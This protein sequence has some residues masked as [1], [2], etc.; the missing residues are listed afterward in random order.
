M[1]D[2]RNLI[3]KI[4]SVFISG[5]LFS[6]LV[7][8]GDS[9]KAQQLQHLDKVCKSDMKKQS[10]QEQATKVC[11]CLADKLKALS[12][13]QIAHL[14]WVSKGKRDKSP[15]PQDQGVQVEDYEAQLSFMCL[16][17]KPSATEPFDE[18]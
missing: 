8:A 16:G 7:F 14:Y 6:I 11:G 4:F 13:A 5:C 9:S 10:N 18:G 1:L 17:K 2:K 15:L 3:M 12:D